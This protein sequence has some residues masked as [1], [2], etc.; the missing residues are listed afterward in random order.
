MSGDDENKSRFST[1]M[2]E[3]GRSLGRILS[4]GRRDPIAKQSVSEAFPKDDERKG[5]SL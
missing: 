2:Y 4:G 3:F 1:R 5:R